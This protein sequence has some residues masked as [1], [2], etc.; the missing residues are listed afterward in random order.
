MTMNIRCHVMSQWFF[1]L[2]REVVAHLQL[3]LECE[4]ILLSWGGRWTAVVKIIRLQLSHNPQ[5]P[6]HNSYLTRAGEVTGA[7][8]SWMGRLVFD[9]EILWGFVCQITRTLFVRQLF[10]LSVMIVVVRCSC[11]SIH[12]LCLWCSLYF[13]G[14][15]WDISIHFFFCLLYPSAASFWWSGFSHFVM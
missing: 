4:F 7:S 12:I 8:P 13:L 15:T 5:E 10:S 6:R 2:F 14:N 11:K 9:W 3:F 1:K